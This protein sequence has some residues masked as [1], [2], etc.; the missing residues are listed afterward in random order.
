M[1]ESRRLLPFDVG[2]GSTEAFRE[3]LDGLRFGVDFMG[4]V[5][6]MDS[7]V[8]MFFLSFRIMEW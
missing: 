6:Q 5:Y 7:W 4:R 1:S 8:M 3:T 2:D